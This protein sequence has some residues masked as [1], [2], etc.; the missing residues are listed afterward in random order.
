MM[1][2][3]R[4]QQFSPDELDLTLLRAS[5]I[6][7]FARVEA[8]VAGIL[9][10]IGTVHNGEPFS[11]RLKEFRKA[12]KT[13]MIAK[14]NL[15]QRDKIADDIAAILA[16]R[17]DIVHSAMQIRVVDGQH[18]AVFVN[19]K[20][21]GTDYPCAR[22]LSP[23]QFRELVYKLQCIN[24]RIAALGRVNPPSS[25]PPPSPGAAGGP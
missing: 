7:E 22:L 20:E 12:E 14:A 17:A 24:K 1:Y 21:A 4:S 18:T 6:D 16:T 11:Q 8:A 5:F 13:A 19:A 25:P 3:A 9:S 15:N 10:S 23:N 2:E